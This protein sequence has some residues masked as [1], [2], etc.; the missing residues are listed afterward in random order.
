MSSVAE[1]KMKMVEGLVKSLPHAPLSQMEQAL[2]SVTDDSLLRVRL[3]VT[4]ELMRRQLKE[5]IFKVYLPLFE[6]REDELNGVIFP[7]WLLD[8]MWLSL[9]ERQAGLIDKAL[10]ALSVPDPEVALEPILPKLIEDCLS[11]VTTQAQSLLPQHPR[12]NDINEINDFKA[13]LEAYKPICEGVSQLPEWRAHLDDEKTYKLKVLYKS[14]RQ[15]NDLGGVA[16]FETL[17]S[18]M[19]DGSQVLKLITLATN[20]TEE[21]YLAQSDL[22]DFGLRLIERIEETIEAVRQKGRLSLTKQAQL[23]SHA[24]GYM[25]LFDTYIKFSKDGPWNIRMMNIRRTIGKV[26]EEKL[27]AAEKTLDKTFPTEKVRGLLIIKTEVAPDLQPIEDSIEAIQFILAIRANASVGGFSTQHTKVLG[28]LETKLSG[29]LDELLFVVNN[30][31]DF[32][33]DIMREY[34]RCLAELQ[35]AQM[36]NEGAAMIMRRM[37]TSKL[38][39]K[40]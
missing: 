22:S 38:V 5:R 36:G 20:L 14:A 8:N 31:D 10:A 26:M 33:P 12:K 9:N 23:A 30:T 1:D 15:I 29:W 40:Q 13:F 16:F 35:R 25:Q 27:K 3:M 39:L 28:H 4:H 21:A 11:V 18:H 2:M 37:N 6:H 34:F 32:N 19:A 7:K 17:F 24:L